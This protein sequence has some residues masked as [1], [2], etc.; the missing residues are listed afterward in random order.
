MG[1]LQRSHR[2]LVPPW[3]VRCGHRTLRADALAATIEPWPQLGSRRAGPPLL[4]LNRPRCRR[5]VAQ[6]AV[7]AV[8][9]SGREQR[10]IERLRRDDDRDRTLLGRWALC[11]SCCVA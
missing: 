7:A 8:L 1:S 9:L 3:R 5:L 4:W 6:A 11:A 10:R 2:V